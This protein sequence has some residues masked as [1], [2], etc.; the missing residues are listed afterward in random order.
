MSGKIEPHLLSR[1]CDS[2]S[3]SSGRECDFSSGRE[4]DS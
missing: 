3:L 4:C 2:D 1:Q